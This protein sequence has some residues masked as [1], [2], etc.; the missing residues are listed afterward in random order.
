MKVRPAS[1]HFRANEGFSLNYHYV[2]FD[3]RQFSCRE[4][5]QIR[6]RDECLGSLAL[7]Q[8][9]LCGLHRDMRRGRRGSR[10]MASL[11]HAVIAHRDQC[12]AWLCGCRILKL[13][14]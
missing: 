8:S 5:V 3:R 4:N 13:F 1:V 12:R 9:V 14:D 11:G 6:S 2:S 7:L 10:H